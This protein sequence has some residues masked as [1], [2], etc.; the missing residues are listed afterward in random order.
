[1]N[2]CEN[3]RNDMLISTSRKIRLKPIHL[4]CY[5]YPQEKINYL[6]CRL[7]R[8]PQ[9]KNPKR[10]PMNG[11]NRKVRRGISQG[12]TRRKERIMEQKMT[13]EC[14]QECAETYYNRGLDHAKNGELKLAIEDY[15]RAIELNPDYAD[16]YYRRSKAWLHLGETEKAKADMRIASSLG[17]N[18][19]TALDETLQNYD[20]AWKT[21]GNL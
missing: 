21:L 20:R 1:L 10:M 11:R 18:V 19:A 5:Y 8:I 15:T 7:T 16:A 4:A 14:N 12:V 6:N 13:K 3:R 17:I 2:T 9:I